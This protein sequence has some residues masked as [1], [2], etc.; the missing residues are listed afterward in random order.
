MLHNAPVPIVWHEVD[1]II[2]FLKPHLD[3]ENGP[4]IAGGC[5]RRMM[6]RDFTD[7][8]DVDVF[9]K[10][11]E[12]YAR[13]SQVKQDYLIQFEASRR[14]MTWADSLAKGH[15]PIQVTQKVMFNS[16][17]DLLDD[18]DFTVC[19]FISD[20]ET[21]R[22]S[23]QSLYDAQQRLL[24]LNNGAKI[25]DVSRILRYATYGF[26]A[27]PCVLDMI[28]THKLS[29]I[30]YYKDII[31]TKYFDEFMD[32]V[33][34]KD[35]SENLV[36]SLVGDILFE[37]AGNQVVAF[38]G[39]APFPASLALTYMFCPNIRRETQKK[40]YPL[41][42]KNGVDNK[43]LDNVVARMNYEQFIS[44]YRAFIRDDQ[45]SRMTSTILP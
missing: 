15:T 8:F 14:T 28:S 6:T 40:L 5:L 11:D 33:K 34:N 42:S 10:N 31:Y 20:G 2:A 36:L 3:F 7:A 43:Q 22:Y 32:E 44:S 39:G 29:S 26:E 30:S 17:Q 45:I 23:A 27:L 18:F 21:V 13:M 35:M 19:Q 9:V 4:W 16:A 41:W 25:K 12:Q 37:R 24:R 1:Q 38:I